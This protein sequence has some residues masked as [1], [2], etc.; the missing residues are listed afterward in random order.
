MGSSTDPMLEDQTVR[1]YRYL[2]RTAPLDALQA[3][4]H[5]AL[6]RL[7]ADQR[8]AVLSAVQ[9]G[10]VAGQRLSPSDTTA[11]AR[12]VSLG[13]RRDPRGFL[14]ACAPAVVHALADAV[15]QSEAAFG[16]FAGYASWDGLDPDPADVGVDHGGDPSGIHPEDTGAESKAFAFNHQLTQIP[17][18][19][20]GGGF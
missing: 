16:L 15:N 6:D 18:G 20:G 9:R 4:H 3:A 5:D 10:L 11:I 13:E 8:A 19:A 17:W 14:D 2:L 12:L 7:T 1:Q